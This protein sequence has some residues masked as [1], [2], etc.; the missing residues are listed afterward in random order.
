MVKASCS[1]GDFINLFRQHGA[2]ETAR[3]L[4]INERAAH[5]RRTNLEKKYGHQIKAPAYNNSNTRHADEHPGRIAI[6]V[7]NGEVIVGSDMHLWPGD[8][9]TAFRGMLK[10]CRDMK[11]K[12][13][14]ANGDVM[15]FPQIS[16]HPPIGH[17]HL[18]TVEDEI[19]YAQDC[20][21]DLELASAKAEKI[22]TLGNHDARFETRLATVAPE[23]ARLNGFSLKNYFPQ[24][25]AAWSTWINN[26][27]VVK[28]R[29]KGGQGATRANALNSGMSMVTGH[30]HSAKVTP[31]TDYNGT[32]Y[33]VDTGCVADP[34][35]RAFVDY[36]ED[37]PKDWRSA[38]CVL[39]FDGGKMLQPE[40]ALVW[41]GDHVQF[42]GK[43]IKV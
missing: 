30:L 37:S 25:G 43:I 27:A 19:E 11:P 13:V 15:D 9:T 21:A 20:M 10:F 34:N 35:A 1:D 36:T 2:A 18:P 26:E 17:Q 41:G 31:I 38:F 4:G 22:W 32:R 33:G 16:R 24:W 29:W 28:H 40:L 12:A 39:T 23:F 6:E 14:V 42:R 7:K 5:S 3:R 8:R